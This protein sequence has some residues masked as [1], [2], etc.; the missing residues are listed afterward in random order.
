MLLTRSKSMYFRKKLINWIRIC[1]RLIS[2]SQKAPYYHNI[3]LKWIILN[4][5]LKY[6]SIVKLNP[7][8][9]I[10][11][12]IQKKVFLLPDYNNTLKKS[13]FEKSVYIDNNRLNQTITEFSSIFKRWKIFTQEEILFHL[14]NNKIKLLYR[15][16]ILQYC[17]MAI[18]TGLEKSVYIKL[19]KQEI[20][21]FPIVRVLSDIEQIIKR[22]NSPR[23][24]SLFTIVKKNNKKYIKYIIKDG[25]TSLSF[26]SFMTEFMNT[27]NSRIS[28]EQRMISDYFENRGTQQFND[29][30]APD[31]FHPIVPQ[32][33]Q[34]VIGKEFSD[35]HEF[36]ANGRSV[37]VP[38]GYKLTRIKFA[39]QYGLGIIGWQ[40]FWT[41]DGAMEIE[42]PPRGSWSTASLGN[43]ELIIPKDDFMS[44]LEY[45]YDSDVIVGVRIKLFF[46]GFTKWIG[47][48]TSLSTLS[49][50]M[51][52]T[53]SCERE[54]YEDIRDSNLHPDEVSDPA[55]PYNFVIGLAG[56]ITSG[57]ATCL[58]L[59]IRKVVKQNLFS[60]SWVGDALWKAELERSEANPL[61]S[62]PPIDLY[63]VPTHLS[64]F[65]PSHPTGATM[66]A[67][68]TETAPPV[69]VVE[70]G[71]S[72]TMSMLNSSSAAD[73]YSYESQ[74]REGEEEHNINS[75]L[76]SS[77]GSLEE[78]DTQSSFP[79][80][81][82][83]D[84]EESLDT[85][86]NEGNN[87]E[88]KESLPLP[89]PRQRRM[90]ISNPV[91][92]QPIAVPVKSTKEPLT[93]SE[94]Q[95]FDVLR[96]RTTE[97]SHAR[98]RTA[99]FARNLWT[100][101]NLRLDSVLCKLVVIRI[102]RGL[103]LWLFNALSK[104]LMPLSLSEKPALKLLRNSKV[105][106]SKADAVRNRVNMILNNAN[107]L[108][109]SAQLWTGKHLLSPKERALKAAHHQQIAAMRAEAAKVKR[110]E[111]LLRL[112]AVIDEKRGLAQMPKLTLSNYIV[113]NYRLKLAA[114]RHKE[115]LLERMTLEDV[116]T[117]L[118]GSN[119]KEK[120]L[121]REQ[122]QAIH[123]SL[124]GQQLKLKDV[125]S[126]ER[127]IDDVVDEEGE[128]AG[129]QAQRTID[130]PKKSVRHRTD[131]I[132]MQSTVPN[133]RRKLST[134]PPRPEG[135]K[136]N[137][138]M[139]LRLHNAGLVS[140]RSRT[141]LV[142]TD[143]IGSPELS[144]NLTQKP[145]GR[146]YSI[147]EFNPAILPES[148]LT[149]T[150]SIDSPTAEHR[151]KRRTSPIRRTQARSNTTTTVT[152]ARSN[153]MMSSRSKK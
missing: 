122:M 127:L 18:K 12:F 119:S 83:S 17:F 59:V 99:E 112:Q 139:A 75:D 28:T 100:N 43:N 95:F 5:W 78:T 106:I 67:A 61:E 38:G 94:V 7:T 87:E 141:P 140:N 11:S 24:K 71:D 143:R 86:A 8:P 108:E 132:P 23:R 117:G 80:S 79:N 126:L 109:S 9:G 62:L 64:N 102:V 88:K 4:R 56:V 25:Q 152:T 31:R 98:S 46:A 131:L 44:G 129:Q 150:D 14:L 128:I 57:R 92:S 107:L 145:R 138:T 41:A 10:I 66:A 125:T 120:L 51:D 115:S 26:K 27:T 48:K 142:L 90:G 58:G 54:E 151:D 74:E 55:Y 93:S 69:G 110:D 15:L 21:I 13:G 34:K 42:S 73:S 105:L 45:L 65:V 32:I 49:V 29:L 63:S 3:R 82:A 146:A 85:T 96:M 153:T 113:N 50:Y 123:E 137:D 68:A 104:R 148:S 84:D 39:Y 133:N 36:T 2:I 40:L 103:S 22:F 6:I 20:T 124:R 1:K 114:A 81:A 149:L 144:T 19:L 37:T 111:N 121:S 118:F 60:Y 16:K 33:M 30:K 52:C 101:K 147:L 77:V 134:L 76:I 116:K 53:N 91:N 35:P 136:L 130:L 135:S 70:A 97:L 89:K 47:G 72:L